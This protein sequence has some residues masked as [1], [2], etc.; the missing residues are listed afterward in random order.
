MFKFHIDSAYIMMYMIYKIH[1]NLYFR[2]HK[3]FE[4]VVIKRKTDI[5]L[6]IILSVKVGQ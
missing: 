3:I 6:T 4:Y 1:K 5:I 2:I